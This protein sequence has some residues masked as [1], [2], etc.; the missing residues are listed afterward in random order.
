[1]VYHNI[2]YFSKEAKILPLE[3]VTVFVPKKMIYHIEHFEL[4]YLVE[5]LGGK[6]VH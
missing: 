3:G 4:E 6:F 5:S 2:K 1:M